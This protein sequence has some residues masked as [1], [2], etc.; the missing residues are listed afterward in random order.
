MYVNQLNFAFSLNI[1]KN[2]YVSQV[3]DS[4]EI[5]KLC[6]KNIIMDNEVKIYRQIASVELRKLLCEGKESS[7]FSITKKPKM[8]N[9]VL[10]YLH[11]EDELESVHIAD[12]RKMLEKS[13]EEMTLDKWLDQ[14]IVYCDR[15]PE[16]ISKELEASILE[17]IFKQMRSNSEK[18][19]IRS[20]FIESENEYN[21]GKIKT[22]VRKN[23]DNSVENKHIFRILNKYGYNF[24]DVR[25]S[26]K[27][28]ANKL[29]AHTSNEHPI[30]LVWLEITEPYPIKFDI[31]LL[32]AL[33]GLHRIMEGKNE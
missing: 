11:V 33:E 24:I 12:W 16:N 15:N 5:L 28:V 22:F 26:I 31:I 4:I 18:N 8:P 17:N 6:M 14:K 29:G 9:L 23:P 3:N 19:K 13:N 32:K 1:S 10:E 2:N 25:R 21:G 30:G 7:I 20:Y 27:L